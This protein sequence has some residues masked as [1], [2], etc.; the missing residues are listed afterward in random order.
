MDDSGDGATNAPAIAIL[1]PGYPDRAGGVRDHTMRLERHWC[2][3]GY[4]VR[5]VGN[6]DTPPA[7]LARE[8]GRDSV[9][10]ALIQYVPFLYG[11]RGLSLYP[12]RLAHAARARGIR[13]SVFV[14]EPWVPL[15]RL[16]WLVLSPLQ[17][18]QLRRL[19]AVS[20]AIVT[21]VPAWKQLLGADT[22]ILPV[23]S[24]LGGSP[25]VAPEPAGLAP[26][27]FSPAAAGLNLP[28]I[29]AAARAIAATPALTL[30]GMSADDGQRHRELGRH[31]DPGWDWSGHLPAADALRSLARARLVLAPFVDGATARRTSLLAAL[32]AGAR[33]VSSRGP[34][35]DPLFEGSPV[36]LA[37]T[38]S[39][40]VEAALRIWN[41]P[42][43][44]AERVRRLAWYEQ[45]FSVRRLDGRL[46][47]WVQGDFA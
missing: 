14:H 7:T 37:A 32:G 29:L 19:V 47:Q 5:I 38:E 2:D 36:F 1:S 27:V 31:F 33:V 6:L 4:R 25:E 13:V 42:D 20:R 40:F 44:P 18:L 23:G 8:W 15:T 39:E 26:V 34:L 22:R 35:L 11:R 3:A 43:S 41:T 10:A 16:S 24:C 17:R 45:H 12:E 30:V 9:G 46:L 28:W 21:A